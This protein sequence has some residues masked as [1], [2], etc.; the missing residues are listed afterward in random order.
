LNAGWRT[1]RQA[2]EVHT[3]KRLF[4]AGLV[5]AV[6]AAGWFLALKLTTPGEQGRTLPSPPAAAAS[7][8]EK[9]APP[10]S[11]AASA[12]VAAAGTTASP[13]A[14]ERLD[15]A[16]ELNAPEKTIQDDLRVLDGVFSVYQ[17]NFLK[18]G[19]PTGENAE[20]TATLTGKNKL[21]VAFI[22]PDHPA[23]NAKGELCDRW[24]TPF[25]F[26]QQ[27]GFKMEIRSAGPDRQRGTADDVA[28]SP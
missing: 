28:Y 8:E 24:G 21:H 3:M 11:T 17:T 14:L 5:L 19:N 12:R 13:I 2:A 1:G 10:A 23:I 7:G 9:T 25:F 18:D 26:H 4:L 22:A 15:L 16:K 6:V 20:I 27:S